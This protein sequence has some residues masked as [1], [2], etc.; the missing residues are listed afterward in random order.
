[1]GATEEGVGE[2]DEPPIMAPG[3]MWWL[4]EPGSPGGQYRIEVVSSTPDTDT[5]R[6]TFRP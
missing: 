2:V 5:S 4:G 1:V 3:S 6:V